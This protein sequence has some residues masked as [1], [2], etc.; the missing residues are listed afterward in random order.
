MAKISN[1]ELKE[2]LS[3]YADGKPHPLYQQFYWLRQNNA[4]LNP[5]KFIEITRKLFQ[6]RYLSI[7]GDDYLMQPLRNK[8]HVITQAGDEFYREVMYRDS[9]DFDSFKKHERQNVLGS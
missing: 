1:K 2:V 8:R 9:G 6:M 5:V 3:F 7:D 4:K